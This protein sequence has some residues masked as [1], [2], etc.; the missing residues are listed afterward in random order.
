MARQYSRGGSDDGAA[1]DMRRTALGMQASMVQYSVLSS[2]LLSDVPLSRYEASFGTPFPG[3]KN[4][5]RL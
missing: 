5:L 3:R 4:L 1:A 2:Y